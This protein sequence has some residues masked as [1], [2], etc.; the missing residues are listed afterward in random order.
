MNASPKIKPLKINHIPQLNQLFKRALSEDFA[1][2]PGE[3]INN[4][5]AQNSPGHFA[6]AMFNPQRI[7]L[8]LFKQGK[9]I[10]YAIGDSS[11]PAEADIFWLYV[12]PEARGQ[13][14][15]NELLKH[16]LA[17][18]SRRGTRHIYL[19]THDQ[20]DFYQKFGFTTIN[21]NSQLFAGLTVFEMC[22]DLE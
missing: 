22:K 16:L 5:R 17:E 6:L 20:A 1:Y 12:M 21:R 10:G 8:G 18:F 11:S 3:Y 4:V 7:I 9:L 19:V 14:L 13:K 2:F 15:G